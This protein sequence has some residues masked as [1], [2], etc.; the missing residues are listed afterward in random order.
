MRMNA[1]NT[2]EKIRKYYLR[3]SWKVQNQASFVGVPL[4]R[5]IIDT[6]PS[7]ETDGH[8]QRTVGSLSSCV[9]QS[10]KKTAHA[11]GGSFPVALALGSNIVKTAGKV[12]WRNQGYPREQKK[13]E[14]QGEDKS[15]GLDRRN[16]LWRR[17]RFG[18]VQ[19]KYSQKV[20]LHLCKVLD[21]SLNAHY[22]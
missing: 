22:Y 15:L 17:S 7:T 14:G 5:K 18:S 1:V 16:Y 12:A 10:L 2:R 20:K 6:Q 11:E 8:R 21:S 19:L 3:R 9:L 13:G 4:H